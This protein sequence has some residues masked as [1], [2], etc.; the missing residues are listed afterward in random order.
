MFMRNKT[1]TPKEN[2]I[3]TDFAITS[4][5]DVWKRRNYYK[6]VSDDPVT[7]LGTDLLVWRARSQF[8]HESNIL[9][10]SATNNFA[11]LVI[12]KG[13][14]ASP[15]PKDPSLTE[16]IRDEFTEWSTTAHIDGQTDLASTLRAIVSAICRDGDVLVYLTADQLGKLKIDLI[17]GNRIESP[18]I[19]MLPKNRDVYLGVQVFKRYIEGYWVRNSFGDRG[20]TFFPAFDDQGRI[21]SVLL[22]NPGNGSRINSYR[23][24]PILSSCLSTVDKLEQL[25]DAELKAS[26]LK[27]LQ[28]GILKTKSVSDAS[29]AIN[30]LGNLSSQKIQD[31]TI[32]SVPLGDDLTMHSGSENSNKD[33]PA[34]VKLYLQQIASPYNVPY[35]VIYN[36]LEDSSY[37]TNSSIFLTAWAN[38]EIW[39]SYLVH[40][41]LKPIYLQ[42]L[43]SYTID[44]TIESGYNSD[45]WKV[46]FQGKP[47][48]PIRSKDLFEANS[49][50]IQTGQKSLIQI[51]NES[52]LDAY[53]IIDDEINLALYRKQAMAEKGLTE[54]DLIEVTQDPKETVKDSGPTVKA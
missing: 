30:P 46:E 47:N 39:R 53:S 54:L 13:L 45:L 50:A 37:S 10:D 43:E 27:T 24:K 32:I 5:D 9:V 44:G 48:L 12:G 1:I 18:P 52:G 26:I 42:L 22:K 33:L 31:T 40:N 38:T 3:E 2:Y 7:D 19:D 36:C 6:R 23:G 51:C 25:M 29:K 49:V 11:S 17:A 8:L 4:Y 34:T 41:L 21:K 35:N 28:L 15:K 14:Y 20:Y 16:I